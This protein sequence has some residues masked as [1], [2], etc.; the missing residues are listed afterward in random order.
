MDTF[1]FDSIIIGPIHSR[2]LGNSLGVNLLAPDSKLC[3]FNCIYC[4]CGWNGEH[5]KGA[6]N[7]YDKVIPA[8]EAK[9]RAMAEEEKLPDV[10]TFAGNGEPTMHPEFERIIDST[11][12]LRDRYARGAKVAV[13]SNATMI[14]R[15]AV[16]KALLR[17]DRNILK[18]D[19]AVD[20]TMRQI[21]QPQNNRNVAEI[22]DLLREFQGCLVVQTMLLRGNYGG[23]HID[24][25]TP[26]EVR[27][28]LD[29][30]RAIAP[31]EVM[32]Y[33]IDRNTPANDL[34]KVSYEDMDAIAAQIRDLDLDIVTSVAR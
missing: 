7:P 20:A 4:E 30:I 2:R 23:H 24:N 21:N 6:F 27:A 22:I 29:A 19:S 33:T 18:F 14:D 1:L 17:V 5:G 16:R 32:L 25:T 34:Q 31:S 9:L 3:N 10:I 11:L 15:D 12:N 8:L 28:Y 26:E 13:L